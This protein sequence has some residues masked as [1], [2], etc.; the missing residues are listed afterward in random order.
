[1]GYL[2]ILE[3]VIE[4]YGNSPS[5]VM[6]ETKVT[7][8]GVDS[9]RTAALLSCPNQVSVKNIKSRLCILI[10]LL[11]QNNLPAKDLILKRAKFKVLKPYTHTYTDRQADSAFFSFYPLK[12]ESI[13]LPAHWAPTFPWKSQE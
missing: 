3:A 1:M 12:H 6:H 7:V 5:F 11:T 10:K 2:L 4:Q 9:I 13:K 8:G